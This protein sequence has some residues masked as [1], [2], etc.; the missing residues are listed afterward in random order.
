MDV[1]SECCNINQRVRLVFSGGIVDGIFWDVKKQTLERYENSHQTRPNVLLHRC[2]QPR[3]TCRSSHRR[4]TPWLTNIHVK[5]HENVHV[6]RFGG[7]RSGHVFGKG[8]D[9]DQVDAKATMESEGARYR[10]L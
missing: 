2:C 1:P 3:Q 5:H 7:A 6:S 9:D 4:Y 8:S 10:M